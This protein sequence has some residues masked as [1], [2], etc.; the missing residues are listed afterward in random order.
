MYVH[1]TELT[2]L[3]RKYQVY[4]QYKLKLDKE[5]PIFTQDRNYVDNMFKIK[6]DVKNV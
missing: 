1:S 4:L 6:E 5:I 2:R 3:D